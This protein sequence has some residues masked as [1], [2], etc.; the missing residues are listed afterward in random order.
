MVTAIRGHSYQYVFGRLGGSVWFSVPSAPIFKFLDKFK[1]EKAIAVF[2]Y[3]DL[4]GQPFS[5]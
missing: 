2:V 1:R 5:P 4:P 3:P